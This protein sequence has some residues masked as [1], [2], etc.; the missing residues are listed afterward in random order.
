MPVNKRLL[1]LLLIVVCIM[2]LLPGCNRM[3][4]GNAADGERWYG[5]NRC[6]ACHGEKGSGGKGPVIAGTSLSF[7][8]FLHKLRA[9]H[10]AIMPSYDSEKLP[11]KDAGEIYLWLIQQKQ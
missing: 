7:N 9:P 10:S 8:R 5:L 2:L 3:P 6:Y 4:E 1:C 11:D